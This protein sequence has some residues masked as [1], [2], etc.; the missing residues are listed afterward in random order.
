MLLFLIVSDSTNDRQKSYNI[1]VSQ[2][3][4][5]RQLNREHFAPSGI[6]SGLQ[7]AD[8]IGTLPVLSL[9]KSAPNQTK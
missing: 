9:A 6:T 4:A 1:E 8:T 7:Q 5:P 2:A 3:D